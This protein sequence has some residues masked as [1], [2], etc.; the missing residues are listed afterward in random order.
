M[1][2]DLRFLKKFP[3]DN[4]GLYIVYELYTFDNLFR[5]FLKSHFE[6]EETLSFILSNCLLSAIVFQERIHNNKY[7]RLS[8]NEA[9]PAE[10]AA[11][12]SRLIY[13][14]MSLTKI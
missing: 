6:Y 3:K 8:A 13:D 9:L 11:Y 4:N 2:K 7:K 10:E 5:L 12:K 14:L 1:K